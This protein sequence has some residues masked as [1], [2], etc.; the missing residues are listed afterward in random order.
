M[1]EA[2]V[3]VAVA[4]AALACAVGGLLMARV[5]ALLPEPAP[6]PEVSATE[7]LKQHEQPKQPYAEL[8][9]RPSFVR[10]LV[11]VSSVAGAVLAWA[12]GLD[13]RLLLVLPL[14]VVG[15]ALGL[16][17]LRTRLL[18]TRLVLPATGFALGYGLLAWPLTGSAEALVRSLIG[19]V[20]V[21][22]VFWVLW[23]VRP[24][25]MGFGDV[26]LSALL[27]FVLA[28]LGWAEL[29]VGIYLPFLLFG[30]PGLVLALVRRDRSLLRANYPFGPFLLLGALI[31]I[32][33]AQPLAE[34]VLAR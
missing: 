15:A 3:A 9:R 14:A 19:L 29:V 11:V 2:A 26:R 7:Q 34:A 5:V 31:G 33:V 32:V 18:P 24:T 10:A 16:V 8:A 21:R 27:G 30:V 23:F 22:S 12:V 20:V 4:V 17:D 25:G 1:T 6:D 28:Y 13:W